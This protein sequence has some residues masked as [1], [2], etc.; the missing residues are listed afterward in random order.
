[1][2]DAGHDVAGVSSSSVT[3][4]ARSPG[5]GDERLHGDRAAVRVEQA[6]GRPRGKASTLLIWLGEV[7]AAAGH[8]AACSDAAMR[9]DLR[10]GVGSANTIAAGRHRRDVVPVRRF[11]RDAD[12]DVRAGERR[13]RS[14]STRRGSCCSRP[15]R[16]HGAAVA[17]PRG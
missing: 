8:D 3:T 16:A 14:P 17:G 6:R 12:E 5:S 1:V 11:G 13:R 7:A 2:E 4:A 9:V 15:R 10:Y